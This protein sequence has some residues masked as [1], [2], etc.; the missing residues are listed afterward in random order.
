[1][2]SPRRLAG[3]RCYCRR[4]RRWWGE[5]AEKGGEERGRLPICGN[6]CNGEGVEETQPT[7][8]RTPRSA[9]PPPT[10]PIPKEC[11]PPKKLSAGT[12]E[13]IIYLNNLCL[14]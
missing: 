10:S 3:A 8:Q 11:H 2:V 14:L 4:E 7:P 1:M 13:T 12:M 5:E 9:W 6:S